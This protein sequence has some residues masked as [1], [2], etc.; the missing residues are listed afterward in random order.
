MFLWGVFVVPLHIVIPALIIN[1]IIFV[2]FCGT[3]FFH[4]TVAH[5]NSINPIVEKSLV[6][7]SWLGATSSAIAWA[8]GHRKHHRYSDTEKDP[9]SPIILG[10]FKAY[11]QMSNNNNDLIKYVP[12]LL[13]KK[14]YVFQHKYYFIVLVTA[15]ILGLLLLPFIY[16]WAIFIVSGFVMWFSGSLVNL[17]GHNKKGPTNNYILGL[18]VGGEG[19]HKNHHDE[20][21]NYSFRHKFDWG[22]KIHQL[23]R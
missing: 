8:G 10:K 7:L 15:H 9:H 5:K 2:G 20:P 13:R 22:G 6:L 4:R 19:W 17:F 21:A 23:L 1:Q 18:L 12:D 14:L 3:A 11:W 16:Y